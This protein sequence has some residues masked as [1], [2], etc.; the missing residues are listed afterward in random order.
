MNTPPPSPLFHF[1]RLNGGDSS[2]CNYPLL[3]VLFPF[4]D[5]RVLRR[6]QTSI[7]SEHMREKSALASTNTIDIYNHWNNLINTRI[8]IWS[9]QH[10]G[11]LVFSYYIISCY[12]LLISI[13]WF[14]HLSDIVR[15]FDWLIDWLINYLEFT[16]YLQ[17]F[18]HMTVA[19][20]KKV[21]II[22]DQMKIS[23]KL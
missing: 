4:I 22:D 7:L 8:Y 21:Y 13:S 11:E 6:P 15:L 14:S 19:K 20:E 5:T 10:R 12:I 23:M 9:K 17:K 1:P 2:Q 18:G 16:P 3:V